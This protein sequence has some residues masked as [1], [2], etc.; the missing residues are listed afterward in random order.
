MRITQRSLYYWI[1]H[2]FRG[3][4]LLLL[5]IIL[6][7][8]FFRVVPLEMQKRI[9]NRAIHLKNIHLLFLYCGFYVGAVFFAAITKYAINT[10][11]MVIGQKILIELRTELYRHILQLPL[12]FYR[13]MQPGTVISAMT[14]ELNAIGFFLG[15]ALA[16]PVTSVLTF[17]VFLGYMF[18]LSPLLALLTLAIYPFEII[19][20]PLLQKRYNRLNKKRIKTVRS[21]ANVVN[22]AISGI[23]EIHSH[24][25]FNLEEQRIRT[26]IL[27]LYSLLKH[28]FIVKYGIKFSN[29]LFQSLGPFLLFLVGGYMAID[30]NFTLG[31]LVAFLSAHEKVYDPW[32]ELLEFYQGFQDAQVRYRQIM[33][34]FD[35]QPEYPRLPEGRAVVDFS[36]DITI[37]NATFAISPAVRLLNSITTSIKAGEQVAIVGFSGSGKSTL[38]LCL[39]Q[40]Y[41]LTSGTIS[42][43]KYPLQELSKADVSHNIT[44]ISQHPFIFTGTIRDNL[45][46]GVRALGGEQTKNIPGLNEQLKAIYDTGL[47]EDVI[48]FGFQA[49]LTRECCA[50]FKDKLLAIRKNILEDL[51]QRFADVVEFYDLNSF[52]R[53]SSIRDNLIFG[54]C[55]TGKFD[56]TRLTGSEP[57]MKLLTETGLKKPLLQLGYTIASRTVDLLEECAD[58]PFFFR[59]TPMRPEEFGQFAQILNE[60]DTPTPAKAAHRDLFYQLAFRFIPG[61]HHVAE[62]DSD[63][64]RKVVKAR[65][66]FLRTMVRVKISSC[67]VDGVDTPCLQCDKEDI[68]SPFMPFCPN[69]YLYSRS[70]LENL[71][72]GVMKSREPIGEELSNLLYSLLAKD[73]LDDV[74]DV[75]LNFHVGSQ[76][77]RLSGGQKQKL[78]I[79]R[80]FLRDT[81][82]IF[83]D[84]ATASLDNI[85]QRRIQDVLETKQ[86]E[87][88]TVVAVIH[89]LEN[90][91]L[92]DRI[93]LLKNGVLLEEGTFAELL[94]K[95]G[96][97]FELV[98]GH[99][100]LE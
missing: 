62:I 77:D 92:Y 30:G 70:L 2:R 36:G 32:K 22:E 7:S 64:A 61:F 67:S 96:S 35:I 98:M 5:G 29:N 52:L 71:L 31:A 88:K 44:M 66:L 34:L 43:D 89:R 54:D 50:P 58:D 81:P 59:Y 80:A 74:L 12:Q 99:Q 1:I 10:L 65:R 46:Y 51:H 24:S 6:A 45:L 23:H 28:L 85:S 90:A 3:L 84:E 17:I 69:Q 21:M 14:A 42:Y 8:L 47:E 73:V 26:H 91:A 57:F 16:I 100:Q 20:I 95:R 18:M 83:L 11:Q 40:L 49:V 78:A 39:D 76:G 60:M 86:Q 4:Q 33:N 37:K 9:V 41:T 75:G 53:Y 38:I 94:A 55:P 93:I 68:S 87:G 27:A 25:S 82:I 19:L 63:F 79:A 97:F 48:R 72:F 56:I 15:G 13:G